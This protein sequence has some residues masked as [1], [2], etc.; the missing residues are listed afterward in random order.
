MSH[1]PD[2]NSNLFQ[3]S[4]SASTQK[5]LGRYIQSM[6]TETIAQ[7]STPEPEVARV[8]ERNILEILGALPSEHFG[9]S[10]TTNRTHLGRLLASAMMN[11]YFLHNAYQRMSF[12]QSLQSL[13]AG[14]RESEDEEC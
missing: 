12:E 6:P 3:G 1:S 5:T 14:S 7:L 2:R 9:V 13:Q 8:M 10:I 11:G 4:G